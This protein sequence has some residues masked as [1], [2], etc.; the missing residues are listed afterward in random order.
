MIIGQT[1]PGGSKARLEGRL[2]ILAMLV[3][4]ASLPACA[5]EPPPPAAT[6]ATAAPP[7]PAKAPPPLPRSSIAAV[8]QHRGELGL[9]DQQ[10]DAM[11]TRD[12]E[13]EEEDRA[14]RA[15]DEKR[16]KA[17]QEAAQSGA[18]A[19]NAAPPGR[20]PGGGM[21]GGG[22]PGAG[23]PGGGMG[24][25]HGGHPPGGGAGT[26]QGDSLEDRLD[27]DDTKAYLD[28]EDLL[29]PAQREPAREIASDFRAQLYDRRQQR[30]G[31]GAR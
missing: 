11:E 29:T 20:M 4:G 3:L 9:T 8:V 22:M 28:I 1:T 14:V 31:A 7:P 21:R 26:P 18:N 23:M 15:D 2:I 12:R 17:A 19:R 24:G 30:N 25:P 16:R 13:R 27:A 10:I 6:A 5:D